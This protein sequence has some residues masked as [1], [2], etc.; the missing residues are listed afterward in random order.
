MIR[1]F[2]FGLMASAVIT[3]L[4]AQGESEIPPPS[5]PLVLPLPKMMRVTL[6][7]KE[8]KPAPEEGP[9]PAP[10][11]SGAVVTWKSVEVVK[12]GDIRLITATMTDGGSHD[13]W[14]L[15]GKLFNKTFD[16]RQVSC[17]D[18]Q[19]MFPSFFQTGNTS[20]YGTDWITLKNY[21]GVVSF[22]GKQ[23]YFYE[24]LE[25]VSDQGFGPGGES[26]RSVT[27]PKILQ[28]AWID[29]ETKLPVAATLPEG[30]VRYR[31]AKPPDSPL[32]PPE[33]YVEYFLRMKKEAERRQR[34]AAIR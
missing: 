24:S 30:L 12:T 4:L 20:F 27:P 21:K 16:G 17:G 22:G 10:S 18:Y 14:V 34:E 25:A 11:L 6:L 26:G 29:E 32:T 23:C 8:D 28:R 1:L 31:F 15:G 9:V 7:L 3:S 2:V 13:T 19:P 33:E 5:P